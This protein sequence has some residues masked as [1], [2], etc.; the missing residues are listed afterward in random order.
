LRKDNIVTFDKT[1]DQ[2]SPEADVTIDPEYTIENIITVDG[3]T[4]T[5]LTL[6]DYIDAPADG[7][8][9][10][11]V[12]RTG[13]IWNDTGKSLANSTNQIAKFITDKTISL[14]R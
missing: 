12:R 9:I 5:V 7:I 10:E 4:I 8:F 6:A 1:V 11:V 13:K 3:S 14:P 2:D